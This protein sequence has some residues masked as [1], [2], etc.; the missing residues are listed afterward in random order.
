MQSYRSV[1]GAQIKTDCREGNVNTWTIYVAG[2]AK[3][4]FDIGMSYGIWGLKKVAAVSRFPMLES[5]DIVIFVHGI[6][7]MKTYGDIPGGYPKFLKD[8]A[9]F[10][11]LVSEIVVGETT[12][13]FYRDSSEIWPDA[14]YENRFRFDIAERYEQVPFSDE[15]YDKAIV[16]AAYESIRQAGDVCLAIREGR[17]VANELMILKV[18]EEDEDEPVREGRYYRHHRQRERDKG[19]AKRK[20]EQV[21]KSRG[22]LLCEVCAFDF[23]KVYGSEL[24]YGYAECHHINPL[25]DVRGEVETRLSDLAILCANCHRMIHRYRPWP[26]MSR[27]KEIYDARNA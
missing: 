24:G 21:L 9:Q 23:D 13:D 17:P 18:Q 11:G 5:G 10:K 19:I 25:A 20:K 3:R 16:E 4:N 8:Y 27:L 15:E 7:W 26:T 6:R 2:R 1:V 22:R 14:T 12:S